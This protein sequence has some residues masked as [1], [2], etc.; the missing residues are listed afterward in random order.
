M[1]RNYADAKELLEWAETTWK[2]CYS[3]DIDGKQLALETNQLGTFLVRHG[4]KVLYRGDDGMRAIVAHN[5]I[6]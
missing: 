5:D 2:T 3:Q 4:S 6:L 1:K